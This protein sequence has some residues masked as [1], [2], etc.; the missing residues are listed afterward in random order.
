MEKKVTFHPRKMA[1]S[2]AKA[3]LEQSGVTG[4]NRERTGPD[5]R[6]MPSVFARNWRDLAK[7]TALNFKT[8]KH[9]KK[10]GRK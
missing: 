8:K 4:Y 3:Q 5:G 9:G 7:M 6:K 10:R 1:R 2:M